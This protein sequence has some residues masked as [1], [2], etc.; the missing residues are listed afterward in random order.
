MKK[1]LKLHRLKP[2]LSF[3]A[4]QCPSKLTEKEIYLEFFSLADEFLLGCI[5]IFL[6]HPLPDLS[7]NNILYK[8]YITKRI[9]LLLM[10]PA[11]NIAA[12]IKKFVNLF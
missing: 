1:A 12:G 3:L 11:K 6:I 5:D 2:K 4:K 7:I 10:I 8:I 9:S